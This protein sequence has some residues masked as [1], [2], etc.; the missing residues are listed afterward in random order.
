VRKFAYELVEGLS[1]LH[2]N[3]ILFCDLKPS[4]VLLN[5]YGVLKFADFGLSKKLSDFTNPQQQQ[6]EQEAGRPKAGTPYYMAPE[7]FHDSGVHSFFSDF[8]SLGCVLYELAVGKPPFSSNSL[9]DLITM[10]V[11]GEA[12]LPVEGASAEFNDLLRR[13]LEKDPTKR[14]GWDDVRSHAFWLPGQ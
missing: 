4:N 2:A 7:L 11:D 12:P 8:W 1:Y 10:I 5:E 13:L 9:K 6:Q 14:M 3:G